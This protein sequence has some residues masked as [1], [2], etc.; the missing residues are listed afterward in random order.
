MIGVDET[1]QRRWGKEIA[2]K[3]IYRDPARSTQEHF[4]KSSALR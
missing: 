2:A 1:L 4:A 3:G